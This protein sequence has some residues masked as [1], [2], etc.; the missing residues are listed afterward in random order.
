MEVYVQMYKRFIQISYRLSFL[1]S[2]KANKVI[3]DGLVVEKN[4]AT[5]V[6]DEAFIDEYKSNLSESSNR[7]LDLVI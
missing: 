3:P 6:N 5:H 2:C 4:L 1:N 7:G